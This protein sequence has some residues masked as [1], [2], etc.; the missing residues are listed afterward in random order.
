M[1]RVDKQVFAGPLQSS[2]HNGAS[3]EHNAGSSEHKVELDIQ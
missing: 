1:T 2:K 3:S